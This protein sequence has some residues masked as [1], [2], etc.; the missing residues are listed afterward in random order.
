MKDK[1]YFGQWETDRVI[2]TFFPNQNTGLCIEVGAYDGIKGSN[3]KYFENLGWDTVCIEPN[4][5]IFPQLVENRTGL[6]LCVACDNFEGEAMLEI[7]NFNS[8][9]QSSLTS[10]NTDFR[11]IEDYRTAIDSREL[12]TTKVTT[13]NKII[14]KHELKNIDFISIDTEGTELKVLKGL[15]LDRN[16]PKLLIVENNY[17][18]MDIP[19]YLDNFGYTKSQRYKVNDFYTKE[20]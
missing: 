2:E 16:R 13:L 18:D 3:T 7:F 5:F 4:I 6:S 11:L 14:E 20:Y 15:N 17:N 10:L 1:V 9:V 12:S 8:G 19:D